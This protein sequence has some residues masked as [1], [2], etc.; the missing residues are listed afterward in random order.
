MKKYP[1]LTMHIPTDILN[2][3]FQ[4]LGL[5]IP[6]RKRCLAYTNKKKVCKHNR[7]KNEPWCI[8]HLKKYYTYQLIHSNDI[9]LIL[10]KMIGCSERIPKYSYKKMMICMACSNY[11]GSQGM[12]LSKGEV[13]LIVSKLYLHH[14]S[15]IN[16][17]CPNCGHYNS[18]HRA[19][20][21]VNVRPKNN[22]ENIKI[23]NPRIVIPY[24][25]LNQIYS[26]ANATYS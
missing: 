24:M 14:M 15:Q 4:Y 26:P 10:A 3:I 20:F 23:K 13:H 5:T 9:C 11:N 17:V 25:E 2:I 18:N 7:Y 6:N 19:R 12:V 22:N 8:Q 1:I 21:I 16:E